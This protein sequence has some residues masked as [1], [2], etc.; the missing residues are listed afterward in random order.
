MRKTNPIFAADFETVNYDG[1]TS[2][3]VWSAAFAELYKDD[4]P[5]VYTN[6]DDFMDFFLK[7]HKG[8][9]ILYFHNLKFDGSFL[10]DWL[11]RHNFDFVHCER[12]E[13]K[14]GQFDALIGKMG[15]WYSL[16]IKYKSKFIEIRDSVKL[17][18]LSLEKLGVSFNL[19][20]RKLEMDYKL[21]RHANELITDEEL[22]YIK[23]DIYVLKE[24]LEFTFGE[25]HTRLTIG[26]CCFNEFKSFYTKNEW[27]YFFPNVYEDELSDSFFNPEK[28]IPHTVGEYCHEG[29]KGAFT[30]LKPQYAGI[31]VKNGK[32]FDANSLYPSV[33]HSKSGNRYPIGKATPFTPEQ[34]SDILQDEKKL[35]FVR[36]KCRFKLKENHL[37]TIQI[38]G[39]PLYNPREFL[40]TSDVKTKDGFSKFYL[41]ANDV[42]RV[43]YITMTLTRPDYEQFIKHYDVIYMKILDGVFFNS[44]IG[45]FDNYIDKYMRIKMN[46]KS[47]KRELAKL[48]LNNLYGRMATY[49]DSTYLVPSINPET[50][51]VQLTPVVENDKTPGY[52]PCGAY[53][54]AYA[55]Y[56]TITMAQANYDAFIYC[57][58][59]SIHMF[60]V[61]VK[62]L[63][64]DPSELCAWKHET[65]WDY[66]KFIRAKT[67]LEHVIYKDGE[68]V[69][70]FNN[71]KCAG[72]PE[73]CKK[74]FNDTKTIED[75]DYGLQVRGKLL[76]K[77]VPGG[78]ILVD[79]VFTMRKQRNIFAK[80]VRD[81]VLEEVFEDSETEYFTKDKLF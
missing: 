7:I 53:I 41:D 48:Y 9:A 25:G 68:F 13:L 36:I 57:D 20:H 3:E 47:G 65:S 34:F 29:Y 40:T 71:I 49:T 21:H 43:S 61:A 50:N 8:S 17:L 27:D 42:P 38:K 78:I 35:F 31:I 44:A 51:I 1:A 18:P 10:V 28:D 14:S 59:D 4:E 24:A 19:P 11:L 73:K 32:V 79:T 16:T 52:I 66:A 26:S 46:S 37:P 60:D 33:M 64:I 45:L 23:N 69:D 70:A 5:T 74:V 77:R 54:T 55:R 12:K 56:H 72:M 67:Y 75:F 22:R 81:C 15:R 30:Y 6:L 58:T 63:K 76:P 80:N 62:S 2:T 39:N